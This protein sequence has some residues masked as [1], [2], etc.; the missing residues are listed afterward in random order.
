MKQLHSLVFISLVAMIV[1]A[2]GGGSSGG[3]G[4]A[5]LAGTYNGLATV[6]LS[7]PGVPSETDTGTIQ[8]V[9]DAEGN[10]TT[11]PGTSFAGTGTLDGNKFTTTVPARFLNEPGLTCTGAIIINGTISGDTMTGT[12]SSSGLTCNGIA[13]QL[14]GTFEANRAAA[15]AGVLQRT[16]PAVL[17]NLRDTVR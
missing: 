8:I 3:A 11:D 7:A 14:T 5:H 1:S 2:C 9:V 17:E 16:G 6:T 15:S 10:V 4:G 13:I 12:F